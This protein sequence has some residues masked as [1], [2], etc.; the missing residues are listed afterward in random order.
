M[1]AEA[2]ADLTP[3]LVFLVIDRKAGLGVAWASGGAGVCALVLLGWSYWRG[4]FAA[5]PRLAVVLFTLGLFSALASPAWDHAT[6]LPR[7]IAVLAVSVA[8]VLSLRFRPLTEVY[9]RARVGP[10]VRNDPR[11]QRVNMEMTASWGVGALAIAVSNATDEVV[12]SAMVL[13]FLGWLTP[14]VLLVATV[15]WSARRW[16]LF[17]AALD[18]AGGASG[19][20]ATPAAHVLALPGFLLVRREP[21]HQPASAASDAS[22][23]APGAIIHHLPVTRYEDL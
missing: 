3:W 8:A 21:A 18:T 20:A 22:D 15:L 1:D 7:A 19:E 4:M 23:E 10:S 13:T 14:L 17:R 11:F 2:Y 12:R 5:L 9:T 6:S 16:E